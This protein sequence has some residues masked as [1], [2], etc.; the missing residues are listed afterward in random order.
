MHESMRTIIFRF[1]HQTVLFLG[2][3]IVFSFPFESTDAAD[4][5]STP[6]IPELQRLHPVSVI[7][8]N[9]TLVTFRS[10]YEDMGPQQRATY[11]TERLQLLPANLPEYKVAAVDVMEEGKHVALVKVNGRIMFV[12]V[13]GEQDTPRGETYELLKQRTVRA[14]SGWLE[15]RKAS[16]ELPLLFRSL[17]LAFGATL[18]ALIV[19]MVISRLMQLLLSTFS[20]MESVNGKPIVVGGVNAAP[21]LHSLLSGLVRILEMVMMFS[22]AYLLLTFVFSLFP[23]TQPWS[24]I[25]SGFLAGMLV[26]F[27]RGILMSIPGIFMV[28]VIF[29]IARLVVSVISA[30]FRAVEDGVLSL[31]VFEPETARATRRIVVVL[32]WVFAL[33]VAYPLIPGSETRAFQGVSVFLGLMLSLGSAGLV[34]QLI[35]GI[36]AVYTKAFQAGD[37]VRIGEHEGVVRELGL[38]AAKIVTNKQEI[39]TIPNALLMSSTTINF[40]RLSK[41]DG[42][43]VATEVTIGYDVPWRQVHAMLLLAAMRTKG[44]LG[45]PEP[46]VLQKSLSDF[47]VEYSLRFR[48]DRPE[49][50]FRVLSELHGNIQDAFNEH[51]VQIMS[52]N[53]ESQ[54]DKTIFVPKENWY[55]EPAARDKGVSPLTAGTDQVS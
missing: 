55:A 15:A 17:G 25:L 6:S 16:S 18:L 27:G 3:F 14:V 47:Y 35:G 43:I 51:G 8:W 54:P 32:V 33:V 24:G 39:V 2:L 52:P 28:L 22:V 20:D 41:P 21:Y 10:D 31:R 40:S 4:P 9:R 42:A 1:F 26:E 36:V 38:M 19:F 53:F 23:Y 48:I 29:F 5:V 49:D 44:I 34:G 30:F 50:R 37:Y 13:D 46:Y 7:L 45:N 11:A 12:L